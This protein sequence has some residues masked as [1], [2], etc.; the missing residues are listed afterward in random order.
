MEKFSAFRDPGTGIQPFLRPIPPTGSEALLIATSPLR[1]AIGLVRTLLVLILGILHALIVE[2][3]CQ[4]LRSVPPLH[5]VVSHVFTALFARLALLFIGLPW[6]PVQV[7]SRKRGYAYHPRASEC[8]ILTSPRRR[9]SKTNETWSPG[10][11]DLIVSNWVSTIE[12][13]WLAFRF[14]PIFVLPV[15]AAGEQAQQAATPSSPITRT[16]GRRTGTGSAAIS[17]P[18][19]RAPTPRVPILGFRQTSLF[20]MLQATGHIPSAVQAHTTSSDVKSLEEIR[21]SADR[22]VVVAIPRCQRPLDKVQGVHHVCPVGAPLSTFRFILTP[23]PCSYDPPTTFCPTLA[24][25]IPYSAL[26][27]LP[28]IF[29]LTTSLAPYTLSIRLLSLADAPSSGTFVTSEFTAGQNSD[30]LTEACASLIAQIGKVKRVGFGWED[31]A[32]FLEFYRSKRR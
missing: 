10:A 30:I 6:I 13:L 14:N 23:L 32:A 26:N 5:R 22:P 7:V 2:V 15:S 24:H 1:Y 8:L 9:N 18:A 16:P 20:G 28:H 29:S 12:I 19:A 4:V 11:G 27:P 31:K 17:S 3:V 25:P 21:G